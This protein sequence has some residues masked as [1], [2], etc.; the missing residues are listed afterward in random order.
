MFQV[1]SPLALFG[2]VALAVP[3]VLH[4]WRPPRAT[5]RV[6]TLR[7]FSDSAIRQATRLRW[8]ERL[9]LAVRLLL[10]SA[11]TLL[12]AEPIWKTQP[13]NRAQRWIL[14][15]PETVLTGEALQRWNELKGAGF[16]PRELAPGFPIAH[17]ADV[18][19]TSRD[20][21]EVPAT[22]AWSLIR[23][24]DARLPAGSKVTVFSSDRL[25]LLRSDRPT[26][27]HCEVEWFAVP[28]AE[29]VMDHASLDAITINKDPNGAAAQLR[30]EVMVSNAIR[31][32][33]VLTTVPAVTGKVAL[34]SPTASWSLEIAANEGGLIS[35]RLLGNDE[36]VPPGPWVEVSPAKSL[37]VTILHDADRLEDAR[38][39][40]A[41]LQAIGEQSKQTISVRSQS[42]ELPNASLADWTFWLSDSAP[43]HALL[44]EVRGRGLD[45]FC[46][47]E[48]SRGAAT[49]LHSNWLSTGSTNFDGLGNVQLFRRTPASPDFGA[50]VWRDSFG[51]P[52]L[53]VTPQDAGRVWKFCSR[54]H[55][56]WTDL[57]RSSA[58]PAAIHALLSNTGSDADTHAADR[59]RADAREFLPT[60]AV[61]GSPIPS[62]QLPSAAEVINLHTFFWMLC[63]AL[64][65]FERALSYRSHS[66]R[67]QPPNRFEPSE[68]PILSGR[69]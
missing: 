2:F 29:D 61:T 12:V 22:D 23:E 6:G 17:S 51:E 21:Q 41:A 59:R 5:V 25:A 49:P 3:I 43:P 16:E 39:L 7:F 20:P 14:V 56:D 50:A 69:S 68:E 4:L 30:T 15:S 31:T 53:T 34:P 13:P 46:D 26:M 52:L 63:A 38:Y 18:R 33:R 47:A 1:L 42:A 27:H 32:E 36:K 11:L 58:L 24:A 45:L 40:K 9:L 10:L 35:A 64:F 62:V 55:P 67:P 28:I 57:P 19:S 54:F 48:N 37:T 44:E 65:A 8:H 66:Y 60:A